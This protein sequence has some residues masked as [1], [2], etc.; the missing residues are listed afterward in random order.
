MISG[1]ISPKRQDSIYHGFFTDSH[2][3]FRQRL[4]EIQSGSLRKIIATQGG[5]TPTA[6]TVF[7]AKVE[8]RVDHIGSK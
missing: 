4:P 5:T 7:R 6:V 8:Q 3:G 1:M 2:Y